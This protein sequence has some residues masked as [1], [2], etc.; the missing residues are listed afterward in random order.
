MKIDYTQQN[1]KCR[2]CGDRDEKINN[3]ISECSILGGKGDPLG[4]M[5][6]I[7]IRPN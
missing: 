4:T 3:I 2:L 1:Y 6:E 7:K 5:Q